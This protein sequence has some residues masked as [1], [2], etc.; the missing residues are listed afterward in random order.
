MPTIK[1]GNR[2][3]SFPRTVKFKDIDGTE[4]SIPV[5]YRYR[6]RKEFGEFHDALPDYPELEGKTVDGKTTYSVEDVLEKRS[7]WNANQIMQILD[8]WSLDE[9]FNRDNVKQLCDEM[10]ACASAIIQEYQAAIVEGRL[11]N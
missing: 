11:G 6:T 7:D 3:K 5:S 8:G 4:L 1:L 10:P 2:P 9:E